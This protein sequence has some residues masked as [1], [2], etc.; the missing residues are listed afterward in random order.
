MIAE[1]RLQG[2]SVAWL[3]THSAIDAPPLPV[4]PSPDMS[5]YAIAGTRRDRQP[6]AD[7]SLSKLPPA[8]QSGGSEIAQ[9]VE[10]QSRPHCRPT[11]TTTTEL[12]G[13]NRRCFLDT[14]T[15][16]RRKIFAGL[17]WLAVAAAGQTPR[18]VPTMGHHLMA[19]TATGGI[20]DHRSRWR[21]PHAHG[22]AEATRVM[23]ARPGRRQHLRP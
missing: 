18:R 8:S 11:M 1:K 20:C 12:P 23:P 4:S 15:G 21:S 19:A 14:Q 16:R 7:P 17:L 3:I 6:H 13:Q 5:M 9:R 2:G 10:P 22:A